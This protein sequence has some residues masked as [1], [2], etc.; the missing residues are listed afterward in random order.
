MSTQSSPTLPATGFLRLNQV[1]QFIPFKKTRWYA[2]IQAGEFPKPIKVG[3]ASLY[4]AEDIRRI[5]E[6][7]GGEA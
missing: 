7:L 1:L 4:K 2:G 3:R 6:Q 5:I